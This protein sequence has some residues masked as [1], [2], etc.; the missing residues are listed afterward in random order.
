MAAQGHPRVAPFPL[1][2]IGV[3]LIHLATVAVWITG[4][5]L[6]VT[7]VLRVPRIAPDG[8]PTLSAHLL[9]RFSKVALAVVAIAVL[10]GVIRSASELSDPSE[11]WETAY[12]RSIVYKLLLLCPITLIALYNRRIVTAL[13][14]VQRP[15]GATLRLIRRTASAE[16]GLSAGIVVIASLLVAQ[17]PGG[18]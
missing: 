10:T 11:L 15:N 5:A 17:V 18:P 3:Q 14:A 12:G 9:A 2:Q 13:R 7:V 8:G 1:L 16:L 6:V 4:L